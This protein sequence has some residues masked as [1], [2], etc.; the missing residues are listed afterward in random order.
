MSDENKPLLFDRLTYEWA[1]IHACHVSIAERIAWR[2]D[3]P[4]EP[5]SYLVTVSNDEGRWVRLERWDGAIWATLGGYAIP[6]AWM[7]LPDP[8][9]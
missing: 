8:Y 7:Y 6:E 3:N 4:P 1:R 2:T 5:G 9:V